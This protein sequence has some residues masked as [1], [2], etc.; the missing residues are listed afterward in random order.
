MDDPPEHGASLHML[1]Q[2]HQGEARQPHRRAQRRKVRLLHGV[3][4]QGEQ[5]LV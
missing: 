5:I 4:L 1:P 2:H 3:V